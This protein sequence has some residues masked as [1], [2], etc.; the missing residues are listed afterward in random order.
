MGPEKIPYYT[1]KIRNKTQ[2]ATCLLVSRHP[3]KYLVLFTKDPGTK[4]KFA[5]GLP[6]N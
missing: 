6:I 4:A 3:E 5:I 2:Y 1:L